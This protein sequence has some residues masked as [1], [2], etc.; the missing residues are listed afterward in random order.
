MPGRPLWCVIVSAAP[1]RWLRLLPQVLLASLNPLLAKADQLRALCFIRRLV[2]LGSRRTVV[3]CSAQSPSVLWHFSGFDPR[4]GAIA[5]GFLRP[6]GFYVPTVRAWAAALSQETFPFR[7]N[8]MPPRHVP[9]S[10]K[11]CIAE[12]RPPSERTMYRWEPPSI[13]ANHVSLGAALRE[14]SGRL[15]DHTCAGR[16]VCGVVGLGPSYFCLDDGDGRRSKVRGT[17]LC[18]EV[19]WLN[20]WGGMSWQ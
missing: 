16:V 5:R 8:H 19:C 2:Q 9:P 1:R 20:V 15:S 6:D 11:P 4:T 10:N 3:V 13:R 17:Q 14:L 12:S 18:Y 7:A